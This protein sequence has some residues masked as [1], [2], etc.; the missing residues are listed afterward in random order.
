MCD[1]I[2]EKLQQ[3]VSKLNVSK[4][5]GSKDESISTDCIHKLGYSSCFS[6]IKV[7]ML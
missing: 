1:V 3:C 2:I 6:H 5:E 4:E 7:E